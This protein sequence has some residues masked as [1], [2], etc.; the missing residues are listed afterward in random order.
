MPPFTS[1]LETIWSFESIIKSL[2]LIDAN[3]ISIGF[4]GNNNVFDRAR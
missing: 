3:N 1:R 2:V 4:S